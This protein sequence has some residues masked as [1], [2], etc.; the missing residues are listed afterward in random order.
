MRALSNIDKLRLAWGKINKRKR[1]A[2]VDGITIA[3]FAGNADKYLK[4]IASDLKSE[5]YKFSDSKGVLRPKME[6]QP[7]PLKIAT[8][9]DRV[10]AKALA[11]HLESRLTRFDQPCSFGYHRQKS[12]IKA[13]KAIEALA[14]SG[15][16]WVLEAD[17][18]KFFDNVDR[19]L[20]LK[21]LRRI[22]K[23]SKTLAFIDE[24]LT[25]EVANLD[26][27]AGELQ[28]LFPSASQ[29]IPQGNMLSP[30]LANFYLHDF[31]VAMLKK[32]YGLIRYADDFVVMCKTKDE[33][34]AAYEYARKLLAKLNLEIHELSSNGKTQ[35]R[36]YSDGFNFVGFFIRDKK[37]MASA[38]TRQ[39]FTDRLKEILTTDKQESLHRK[40]Q[41]VNN[42]CRGW[43]TAYALAD[44]EDFPRKADEFLYREMS[45]LFH[46]K[47]LLPREHV[48]NWNQMKFIGLEPLGD[49][50]RKS[51]VGVVKHPTRR[52]HRPSR[53]RSTLSK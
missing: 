29:G 28:G 42:V 5:K 13:V 31:D 4:Q 12:T 17:I 15:S 25:S 22:T 6:G 11:M 34:N 20:L 21:K 37:L 41:R 18:K 7:R 23:S 1:S 45:A 38:K 44:L 50:V 19:G 47:R 49:L 24:A 39:K 27:L 14:E 30:M 3:A 46:A 51:Q 2:G 40:V 8:I 16:R 35:I 53:K 48:L 33:A 26:K 36:R 32:G 9:R 10:V 43:H 52:T